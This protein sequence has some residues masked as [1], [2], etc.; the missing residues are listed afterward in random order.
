MNRREYNTF[1]HTVVG[2]YTK[3]HRILPPPVRRLVI[4]GLQFLEM[5]LSL[6]TLQERAN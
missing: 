6:T 3:R 1:K 5:A 2:K 4:R